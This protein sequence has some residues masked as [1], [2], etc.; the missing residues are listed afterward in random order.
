M[1]RALHVIHRDGWLSGLTHFAAK[2]GC[3]LRTATEVATSLEN[4]GY[5]VKFSKEE[6]S[7]RKQSKSSKNNPSH[8]ILKHRQIIKKK[9]ETYFTPKGGVEAEILSLWTQAGGLLMSDEK[10]RLEPESELGSQLQNNVSRLL[11]F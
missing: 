9:D 7:K 2:I 10:T 5:I 8:Y 11:S 3:D 4:E 6:K 1:R